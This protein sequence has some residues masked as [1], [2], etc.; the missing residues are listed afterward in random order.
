M[1][2]AQV[3]PPPSPEVL[4][5]ILTLYQHSHVHINSNKHG[6]IFDHPVRLW[7]E[8]RRIRPGTFQPQ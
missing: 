5:I 4:V 3:H 6:N 2:I 1:V 7:L 8:Y